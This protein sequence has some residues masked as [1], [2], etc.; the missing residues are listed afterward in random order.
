MTDAAAA[1]DR[2]DVWD[3]LG[4]VAALAIAAFFT[5]PLWLP[6]I[7]HQFPPAPAIAATVKVTT[8][9]GHGSGV[10]IGN[11]LI[12]TAAHVVAKHDTATVKT[13]DD[14]RGAEVLWASAA[15]DVAL[16]TT[17]SSDLQSLPLSCV[18]PDVGTPVTA[19]G[20]PLGMEFVRTSGQVV[21]PVGSALGIPG[22][23]PVDMTII[24]GMSGGPLVDLHGQVV[25]I[26]VAV[27]TF[28][29][30][31]GSQLTGIGMAVSGEAVC[32]LM[33]RGS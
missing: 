24:P 10:H 19:Y 23:Y 9:T 13:T 31:F 27:M 3:A 14:T 12:L 28:P 33:G 22:A 16:L 6:A 7:Q 18:T 20:N 30:G 21:G 8:A 5:F 11:G 29:V 15:Y 26:S 2:L 4:V 25:G 17:S 32:E 1:D